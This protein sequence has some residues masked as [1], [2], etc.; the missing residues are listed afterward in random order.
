VKVAE[1]SMPENIEGICTSIRFLDRND[2]KSGWLI[3]AG[4]V[5]FP[6]R[7][8]AILTNKKRLILVE[9]CADLNIMS[10]IPSD[11]LTPEFLYLYFLNVDMRK[12]GTG[13]SIPQIN[14]YDIAPLKISFP[15]SKNKQVELTEKIRA[16]E[17]ECQSLSVIYHQKLTAL[18]DLKKSLL[19][20]AFSGQ[21]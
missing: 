10:V 14:N 21:L 8:G 11:V 2:V 16:I 13:S 3:P 12:L 19:H 17:A 1:M 7:G 9:M 6:K 18:D 20:Q 15:K 4:A 5:I